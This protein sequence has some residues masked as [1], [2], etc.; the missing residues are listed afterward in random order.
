MTKRILKYPLKM[1]TPKINKYCNSHKK[2]VIS[3]E[4]GD[5]V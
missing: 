3:A 2:L 5:K 1:V 4:S